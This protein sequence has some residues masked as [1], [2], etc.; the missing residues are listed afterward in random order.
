MSEFEIKRATRVGVTPLIGLYSESG[1]GKTYSS[2]LLAR[3]IV[4]PNGKIVMVDSE[5]GRG[6]LYADI[7]PG[8][9]DTL[10]INPPFSPARYVEAIHMIEKSGA[11]IG[12]IDSASHEWENSGGVN[13]MAAEA[14]ARSGKP[15][16]HNWRIPK[17]EH[18]KFMLAM[19]QSPIPWIICLRAKYKTRQGKDERGKTQIVKDD[20]CS[21][22]QA[23]D[24]IFEMT[25]HMDINPDH[26]VRLTKWSHPSLKECFP[27]AGPLTIQTGEK[28]ARWCQN[29]APSSAKSSKQELWEALKPFRGSEKTKEVESA[30][31]WLRLAGLLPEGCS[32]RDFTDEQNKSLIPQVKEEAIKL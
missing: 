25:A 20:H 16:L 21:P 17:M 1:C 15:G 23:E 8:G 32:M 19:L 31:S 14:E 4:G 27:T 26:S 13:D 30:E 24:F 29:S 6:S 3:G 5:S 22:I 9:Y 2:L 11:A 7:L 18:Q 10:Q 28:I 12:V